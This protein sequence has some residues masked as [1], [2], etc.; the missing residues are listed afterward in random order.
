M[1]KDRNELDPWAVINPSALPAERFEAVQPYYAELINS[2][3]AAALVDEQFRN[4]FLVQ[5]Y[6]S[7][8]IYGESFISAV[9]SGQWDATLTLPRTPLDDAREGFGSANFVIEGRTIAESYWFTTASGPAD[10]VFRMDSVQREDRA[11]RID[12]PGG[13]DWAVIYW[14]TMD[15]SSTDGL[16]NL[17][18]SRFSKVILELK[19]ENGGEVIRVHVKDVDYPNDTSPISVELTLTDEWQTWEIDVAEFAPN[20]FSRLHVP[21]GLLI[22]PAEEPLSFSI[23]NARYE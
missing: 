22:F 10:N 20:D 3:T 21:L 18:Y 19:G 5:L 17:D 12:Y 14:G 1:Y 16:P 9:E 7:L 13:D 4:H 6:D 15:S 8:R 23:R 2:P 11:I